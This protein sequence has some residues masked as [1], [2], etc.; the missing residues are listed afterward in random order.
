MRKTFLL[1]AVISSCIHLQAQ[2]F[3]KDTLSGGPAT[4]RVRLVYLGDG[5]MQSELST[6]TTDVNTVNSKLFLASPFKEYR[7]YFNVYAIRVPSAQSGA[8]HASSA[9]DCPGTSIQPI[10]SPLNYFGS[11][12]DVAGIHRLVVP[13]SLTKVQAVLSANFPTYHQAV[14]IVNSTYYGGSG[15]WLATSTKN[16]SAAE[17]AIHEL[18]H[19]F[20]GLADEYWAGPQ[21]AAEK[22]N[23]TAQSNPSLVK[24]KNWVGSEDV[25]VFPYS[26]SPVWFRPVTG[27]KC[28]MEVLGPAFCAVCREAIAERI[29]QLVKP[30]DGFTPS[31]PTVASTGSPMG[32][33]TLLLPPDP[34][35]LKITWKLNGNVVA[36]AIDTV[37]ILPAQLAPG[38]NILMATITDTTQLT[39]ADNHFTS[40]NYV[41]EWS[42]TTPTGVITPELYAAR[43]KVFPN[44][45]RDILFINYEITR[46]SDVTIELF[47]VDGRLV[48]ALRQPRRQPGKYTDEMK[49][50]GSIADGIYLLRFSL[51]GNGITEEKIRIG[52]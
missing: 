7:N 12:F 28:K 31:T 16:T 41:V 25:N 49:I 33:R 50:S 2:V 48:Q 30:V 8:K 22:P 37:T 35:T 13:D 19:S 11:R 3:E 42:I 10:S 1:V 43:L 44:P 47:T 18:G 14:M 24:W 26:G 51:N 21:Y 40:H 45:F 36:T 38:N 52:K 29:H 6:Y 4:N 20:A 17:I 34:N 32:F 23:M 9:P 39:R 15:G 5:Y 46:T 27:G